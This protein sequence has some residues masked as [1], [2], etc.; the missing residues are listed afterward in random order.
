MPARRPGVRA[1]KSASQRLCACRPAQRSSRS[2]ASIGGACVTSAPPGKNG[3]I[4]FGKMTSAAMPSASR[5]RMRRSESQLRLPE[6]AEQVGEQDLVAV[7]PGVELVVVLRRE[8]VAVLVDLATAV[9]VGGDDDVA[10]VGVHG[11]P[12]PGRHGSMSP[13]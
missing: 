4:V 3:G 5:S 1:Q 2:C 11:R 7:D 12:P 8:E 9:A 10:V 6:I 13:H